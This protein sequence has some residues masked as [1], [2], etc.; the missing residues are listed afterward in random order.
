MG[1]NVFPLGYVW[2]HCSGRGLWTIMLK[3]WETLETSNSWPP[4]FCSGSISVKLPP[5]RLGALKLFSGGVLFRYKKKKKCPWTFINSCSSSCGFHFVLLR[6]IF[7]I[8]LGQVFTKTS[9]NILK[10]L[11]MLGRTL[12]GSAWFSALNGFNHQLNVFL[13]EGSLG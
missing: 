10:W 3:G 11:R 4:S 13:I 7:L 1:P 12:L 2:K 9:K 6:A 5:R 8:A